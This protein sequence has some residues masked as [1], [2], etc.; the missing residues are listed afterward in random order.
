MATPAPRPISRE[1][2]VHII[3]DQTGQIT[4]DRDPFWVSKGKDEEV[5]WH[6]TST[7]PKDPHPNFTVDFDKNGSPFNESHFSSDWPCS[8]L[9]KRNV[10]PDR[11]RLYHYTVRVGTNSL[12]PDG[13]VNQ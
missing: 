3:V 12:D 1:V 10:Q 11:D 9:V 2:F 13:G 4:V 5:V 6:C 8:G 7:D